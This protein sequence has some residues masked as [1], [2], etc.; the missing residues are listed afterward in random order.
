[1]NKETLREKIFKFLFNL[2]GDDIQTMEQVKT[3]TETVMSLISQHS[4]NKGEQITVNLVYLGST[5]E[6]MILQKRHIF[7]KEKQAIDFCKRFNLKI[8]GE[9]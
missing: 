4:E 6:W 5:D 3:Q 1:M 9:A 2:S 7:K 8:K